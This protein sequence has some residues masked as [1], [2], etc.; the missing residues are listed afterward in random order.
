[1]FCVSVDQVSLRSPDV[2]LTL[3]IHIGNVSLDK[4]RPSKRAAPPSSAAAEDPG[5]SASCPE[6]STCTTPTLPPRAGPKPAPRA[7]PR[8]RM[9]S[10][11]SPSA[12]SAEYCEGADGGNLSDGFPSKR[13]SQLVSPNAFSYAPGLFFS[14]NQQNGPAAGSTA[15]YP[16]QNCAGSAP[17]AYIQLPDGGGLA[18][19]PP[20]ELANTFGSEVVRD[21]EQTRT[22]DHRF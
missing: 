10:H 8:S 19:Y 20:G 1:M 17:P 22:F 14:Q 13:Q 18:V 16:P 15:P 3:P 11:N 4:K 5:S 12:P 21:G 6:P 7:A 9:S 2:M